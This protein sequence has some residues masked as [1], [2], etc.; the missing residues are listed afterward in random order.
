MTDWINTTNHIQCDSEQCIAQYIITG[1][2]NILF[3]FSHY[4]KYL[5]SL[6]TIKLLPPPCHGNKSTKFH[7]LLIW[8]PKFENL[9]TSTIQLKLIN[10]WN[11]ND[12]RCHNI[13]ITFSSDLLIS[14]FSN[15]LR[16]SNFFLPLY[17]HTIYK[18]RRYF[19]YGLL[20]IENK[21]HWIF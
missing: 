15:K 2:P 1:E 8:Q 6:Q 9:L 4:Q 5:K 20:N 21:N 13:C 18:W 14:F 3:I 7:C 11:G 10:R 19:W 17:Y 16:S 12:R